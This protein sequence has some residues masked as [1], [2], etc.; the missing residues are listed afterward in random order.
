VKRAR[1]AVNPYYGL[2]AFFYQVRRWLRRSKNMDVKLYV[3][4]MSLDTTEENLR[5]L[6]SQ[7]GTVNSVALIKDRNTGQSRGFA[8]VEMDSRANAQKAVTMF[9]DHTINEHQLAV[10]FARPREDH[11]GFQPRTHR[12]KRDRGHRRY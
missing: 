3:G 2:A 6:F 11:G 4:N 5:E 8:F 7:A 9:N 10:N 1:I 12:H